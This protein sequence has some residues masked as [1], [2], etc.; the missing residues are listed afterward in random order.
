M[1]SGVGNRESER[2]ESGIGN[3]EQGTGTNGG[4]QRTAGA[5]S[6]SHPAPNNLRMR[7]SALALCVILARSA[8]AQSGFV[9][10]L[11][12]DDATDAGLPEVRVSIAGAANEGGTDA[13]GR[14]FYAPPKAGKVVLL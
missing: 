9:A 11:V 2:K 8:S 12:I 14:F 5:L 1:D 13:R 4:E 3:R 6:V 7:L 10:L